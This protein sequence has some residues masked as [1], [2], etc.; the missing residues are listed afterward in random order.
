MNRKNS[1]LS[2][3][4][5]QTSLVSPASVSYNTLTATNNKHVRLKSNINNSNQASLELPPGVNESSTTSPVHT[6]G[7]TG[8]KK[9]FYNSMLMASM[10]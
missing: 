2:N 7:K 4:M 9:R 6:V 1:K 5:G 3:S 8:P 10:E